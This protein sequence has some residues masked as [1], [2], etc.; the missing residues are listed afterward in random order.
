MN[1]EKLGLL[2]FALLVIRVLLHYAFSVADY[3]YCPGCR[4][5]SIAPHCDDFL[6]HVREITDTTRFKRQLKTVLFQR[7]FLDL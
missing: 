5:E 2:S 3:T 6:H 4:V 1:K 7:A